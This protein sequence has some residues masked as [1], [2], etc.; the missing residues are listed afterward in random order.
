MKHENYEEVFDIK[1]EIPRITAWLQNKDDNCDF[2]EVKGLNRQYVK[3]NYAMRC[4]F[5]PSLIQ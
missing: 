1:S 4:Y 2:W 5:E 3:D